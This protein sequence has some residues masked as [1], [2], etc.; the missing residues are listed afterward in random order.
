ML[1]ATTLF[2]GMDAVV[3]LLMVDYSL[4]QVLVFRALFG[5]LPLVPL[6]HRAGMGVLF[7]GKPWFHL[8]RSLLGLAA[9]GCFF[10]SFR[11]LPLAN[12]TAIGFA[13]PLLVALFSVVIL[14]EK[15]EPLGWLILVVGFVTIV[16]MVGPGGWEDGDWAEGSAAALTGTVL[17]AGVIVLMRGMGQNESPIATVFWFSMTTTVVMGSTLPWVWHS[18]GWGDLA[19]FAAAGLLGGTGQLL[20]AQALRLAPAS[21]V[22]PFDYFHIVVSASLGWAIFSDIPTLRTAVG[23]GVLIVCGLALLHRQ[24]RGR[25]ASG[26]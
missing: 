2:A 15:V 26:V 9:V 4:A 1:A 25:R 11:T 13:A 21:V 7:S 19:L 17:Y 5:L 8:I 14:K 3:K 6:L 12:V 20:M 24:R 22:V 16:G 18:P 10:L 23:A